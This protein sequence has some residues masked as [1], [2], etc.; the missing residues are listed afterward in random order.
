MLSVVNAEVQEEMKEVRSWA[1]TRIYLR[2]LA[3]PLSI[4]A[5]PIC[6]GNAAIEG[7]YFSEI[8]G[9]GYFICAILFASLSVS[10]VYR[11]RMENDNERSRFLVAVSS[12]ILVFLAV[13]FEI[14]TVIVIGQMLHARG[15]R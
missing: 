3:I 15:R 9:Y 8:R 12:A 5:C 10:L 7:T 4:T 13:A 6:L 14:S 2:L 1:R 11:T